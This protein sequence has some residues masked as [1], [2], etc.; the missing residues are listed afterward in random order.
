MFGDGLG[1]GQILSKAVSKN[2]SSSGKKIQKNK[3]IPRGSDNNKT[4]TLS[5]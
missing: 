2:E 4:Y 3:A 5:T 1:I